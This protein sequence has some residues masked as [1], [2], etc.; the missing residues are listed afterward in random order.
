MVNILEAY[1]LRS[2]VVL[3]CMFTQI[4][5]TK[6][7]VFSFVLAMDDIVEARNNAKQILKYATVFPFRVPKDTLVCVYCGQAHVAPESYRQHMKE[8]HYPLNISEAFSHLKG[9]RSEFLKVDCTELKC[10]LC[11]KQYPDL[12]SIAKH[13]HD[14]HT[15]ELKIQFDLGMQEFRFGVEKWVCAVCNEKFPTLRHV[16]RHTNCHYNK[17]TCEVCGKSYNSSRELHRHVLSVHTEGKS[18]LVC[19]KTFPD[20]KARQTHV[21]SSV[22]CWPS[23]CAICAEKFLSRT[24]RNAHLIKV[25]DRKITKRKYTCPECGL[26]YENNDQYRKHFV[27]THTNNSFQCCYCSQKFIR[28]TFLE[29]HMVIHTQ[30]KIFVCQYCSKSFGRKK[31]LTQHLWSHRERKRFVCSVCDKFF[32]QKQ[33]LKVHLK[34]YH[35]E[36]A[37]G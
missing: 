29:D 25:H 33:R 6:V 12:S 2:L 3:Y 24:E 23:R 37:D 35:P 20:E 8:Q 32:H 13:L 22:R 17:I 26:I 7:F 14:D 9:I 11:F 10:N 15:I 31:Y 1:V 27:L 34:S 36:I 19:K 5:I 28:K 16:S 21:R 30:E 4:A 18:C